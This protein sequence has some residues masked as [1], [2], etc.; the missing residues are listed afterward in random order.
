MSMH[1]FQPRQEEDL[2]P[3]R[4]LVR[5]GVVS[6]VVGA[7]GVVAATAL[8][9]VCI[10]S[11]A[12]D[13]AA[14]KGPGPAPRTIAH[15]EQTPIWQTRAG[16]DL[17]AEQRRRLASWGWVDRDAGVARIPIDR[18]MDVVVGRSR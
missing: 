5:I 14:G 10:G 6:L 2:V 9:L 13:M 15:V 7:L 16:E 12:P 1:S 8:L 17:R 11:V 4:R 3:S 18:A